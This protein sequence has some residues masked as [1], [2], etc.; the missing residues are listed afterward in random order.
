MSSSENKLFPEYYTDS[1]LNKEKKIAISGCGM[2]RMYL[3]SDVDVHPKLLFC[4]EQMTQLKDLLLAVYWIRDLQMSGPCQDSSNDIWL[5]RDATFLAAQREQ[6]LY[7][8]NCLKGYQAQHQ[9]QPRTFPW[10]R[11]TTE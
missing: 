6:A 2:H 10:P 11:D 7:F 1:F 4:D 5:S 8:I 9:I 3:A